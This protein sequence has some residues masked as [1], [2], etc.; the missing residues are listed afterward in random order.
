MKHKKLRVILF[1]RLENQL[2]LVYYMFGY[3]HI[4][5]HKL[6]SGKANPFD[7]HWDAYF[8]KRKVVEF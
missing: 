8:A 7:P 1:W 2:V 6:I 3:F 5:R 4:K